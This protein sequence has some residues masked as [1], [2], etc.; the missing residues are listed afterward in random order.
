MPKTGRQIGDDGEE[1]AAAYLESKGWLILDR[2]YYFEKAEVDI[3]AYD[4]TYIIFVEVKLRS[5]TFFGR[6]EEFVT[7]QKESLVKKA[8]EA[9]VYER[10]ME[11]AL[12]RFD[13]VAIVQNNKEAPDITHFEDAFR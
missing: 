9:W 5:D 6:P 7:P 13:V 10:K 2:N 11:T 1:I 4:H 12:V 3:V 8:A